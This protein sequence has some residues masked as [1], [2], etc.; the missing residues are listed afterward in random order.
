MNKEEL[1]DKV[2]EPLT[3]KIFIFI[4]IAMIG[5]ISS[6]FIWVWHTGDLAFKVFVS[7]IILLF[8]T[9]G[10]LKFVK[11]ISKKAIDDHIKK[12]ESKSEKHKSRFQAK[13]ENMMS[14]AESNKK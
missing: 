4:V 13:L 3:N 8:L 7:S 11:S 6:P 12:I 9:G 2:S 10:A 5:I 14:E 1:V